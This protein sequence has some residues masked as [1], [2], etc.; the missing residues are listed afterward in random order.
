M[1]LKKNSQEDRLKHR[2]WEVQ[3]W[4]HLLRCGAQ[5][6]DSLYAR[7]V[8]DTDDTTK[9]QFSHQLSAMKRKGLLSCSGIKYC[10]WQAVPT[11]DMRAYL[12]SSELVRL[13]QQRQAVYGYLQA[14]G[15]A[16]QHD[17]QQ[18]MGSSLSVSGFRTALDYMVRWQMLN[19]H[20]HLA[21]RVY[22]HNP[23]FDMGE[24]VAQCVTDTPDLTDTSEPTP[25]PTTTA[26]RLEAYVPDPEPD[27]TEPP[28]PETLHDHPR[29]CTSA[30]ALPRQHDYRA[31]TYKPEPWTAP[32]G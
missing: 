18:A 11:F 17:I 32:R 26:V 3:I 23:H 8:A 30:V 19:V 13:V 22:S 10:K 14:H 24:Y 2:Q 15:P 1:G 25:E 5:N 9:P 20:V 4:Q 31:T 16:I 12:Y 7:F 28:A 27:P 6:T 21:K 29:Y